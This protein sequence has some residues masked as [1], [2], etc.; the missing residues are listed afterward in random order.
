MLKFPNRI[1]DKIYKYLYRHQDETILKKDIA[2]A[3]NFSRPTVDK[4]LKW[5][6]RREV[7]KKIGR[8]NYVLAEE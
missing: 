5:L 1:A 3:T 2:L 8:Y 7:V 6:Y 4:Y